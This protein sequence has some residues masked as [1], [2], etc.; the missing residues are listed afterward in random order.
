MK[1]GF[2]RD[3]ADRYPVNMLCRLLKVQRSAYYDWQAQPG[4]VIPQEEL[5]LRR[6][7]KELFR[8]SRGS[9]GSRTMMK[10]L[11][12]E[13]FEIGR[14]RTR[15]LMKSLDLKVRRKRKYKVTTDSKHN[16]PVAQNVLNRAFSPQ[17]PNQAWG[18]DITYC[19]P[20]LG[21]RL[22]DAARA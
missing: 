15:R 2:I 3:H 19:A 18:A 4:K 16:L 14:E 22:D 7:M 21:R 11:N 10:N 12:Q 6:R 5:V 20:S 9:L 17:G 8:S 1:Y 13:G